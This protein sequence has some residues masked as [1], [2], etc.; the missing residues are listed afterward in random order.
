MVE[1]RTP[2]GRI[3]LADE[4]VATIAGTAAVQ[5][6]GVA[7]MVP[8]GLREGLAGLLG[9][10]HHG[11]G[12]E[13]ATSDSTVVVTVRI[14]VVYGVAIAEV[15]RDVMGRVR[16]AVARAIGDD[17]VRVNVYVAGVRLD[18]HIP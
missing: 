10:E 8:R 1:Y 18:D 14:A 16:E 13:V 3:A 6:P 12:V 7:G 11:R 4:V 5:C 9:G 2:Y 15:A 17:N